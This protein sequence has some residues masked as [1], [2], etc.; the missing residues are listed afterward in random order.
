MTKTYLDTLPKEILIYIFNLNKTYICFKK[1]LDDIKNFCYIEEQLCNTDDDMCWLSSYNENQKYST[2]IISSPTRVFISNT[3]NKTL[4]TNKK[5]CIK[6]SKIYIGNHDNHVS[7]LQTLH[8]ESSQ[9]AKISNGYKSHNVS[10]IIAENPRG[11]GI[12]I[13]ILHKIK[14]PAFDG[15]VVVGDDYIYQSKYWELRQAGYSDDG[16]RLSWFLNS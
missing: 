6:Y 5:R 13:R 11:L 12:S 10:T 7:C 16:V 14:H 2:I 9:I 8:I 4:I 15:W 3:H 1:V